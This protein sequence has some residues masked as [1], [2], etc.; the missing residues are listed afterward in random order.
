[1]D[2]KKIIVSIISGISIAV[3]FG[4]ANAYVGL[5]AGITISASIPAAVISV[6]IFKFL[7]RK[8]D[9]K[10][11]MLTTTIGATGEAVAAGLIFTIPALYMWAREGDIVIPNVFYIAFAAALGGILGILFVQPLKKNLLIQEKNVLIFPESIASANVIRSGIS[12]ENDTNLILQGIAISSGFAFISQ[13]LKVIPD[14][15]KYTFS[16]MKNASVGI[17]ILPSLIG[18]GYISGYKVSSCFFAGG[19]IGWIILIPIITVV[20]GDNI[21]FPSSLPI[22]QMSAEDVW[23][24]YIKYIGAGAVAA[25]GIISLV[26]LFPGMIRNFGKSIKALQHTTI[27]YN[28][29][30]AIGCIFLCAIIINYYG[31]GI[32]GIGIILVFGFFFSIVSARM[33]GMLGSSNNPVSGIALITLAIASIVLSISENEEQII[34]LLAIIIGAT[35][36]VAAS[37]A[38]ETSQVLKTGMLLGGPWKIQ[39]VGMI[40]GVIISSLS[41]SC[42]LTLMDKAWGFG[43]ENLTAP[44]AGMMKM[45]VES[46][47][48]SNLPWTFI[49]VGVAFAIVLEILKIPVLPVSVGLYLPISMS[50]CIFLGGILAK[51]VENRKEEQERGLLLGSGLI[52]GEGIIGILSAIFAVFSI[53]GGT[54]AD[55]LDVSEHFS[56]GMLGSFLGVIIL[57]L[58]FILGCKRR[59]R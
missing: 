34:Y 14:N 30:I 3:L 13:V 31:F 29:F 58:I 19:I 15:I 42:I 37:L 24:C 39:E 22:F 49:L 26:K 56:L 47:V 43:T 53:G 16:S 48:N 50:S 27:K 35:V 12:K 9:A 44:Q 7:L 17:N 28:A 2:R 59:I 32:W 54:L 57:V 36:C 8:S 33:A 45:I 25:G 11:I 10:Y 23:N 40:L 21:I 55:Q 6:G 18:V 52:V 1:M 51:I 20:G 41:I 5:K 38:A 4:A 46:T